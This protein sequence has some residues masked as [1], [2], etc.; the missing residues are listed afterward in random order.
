ME[1]MSS[2]ADEIAHRCVDRFA[3]ATDVDLIEALAIAL[4]LELMTRLLGLPLADQPDLQAWADEAMRLSGGLAGP[5]EFAKSW[6]ASE[7]LQAYLAERFDE[8]LASPGEEVM[9]DLARAVRASEAGAEGLELWEALG[10]L[11][12]LVVGGIE[13]TVGGIGAAIC[14]AVEQPGEWARLRADPGRIPGFV[15][16]AVRLDGPAI[17]NLRRIT[18][19]VELAGVRMPKGTTLALLWG[20]ANRDAAQFPE[21]DRFLVGRPNIQDHLGF[22]HGAHFC[23]GASLARMEIRVALQALLESNET[24]RLL[25]DRDALRHK[26]SL[27]VRRLVKLQVALA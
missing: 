5:D 12:Q 2:L 20:S 17:G 4:P 26:P 25:Q 21:P 14:H 7:R 15:E 22:G 27:G 6:E 1:R 11:F 24:I 23:L 13:T 3:R 18:R 16:E 9:G 19:D 10:V 8:E